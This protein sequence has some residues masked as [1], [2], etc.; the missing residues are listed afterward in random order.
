MVLRIEWAKIGGD[1]GVWYDR[2]HQWIKRRSQDCVFFASVADTNDMVDIAQD[3]F[4]ELIRQDA[5][6]ISKSKQAMVGEDG[7]QAHRTGVKQGFV[8]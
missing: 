1:D 2:D 7:P 4:E 8:T 3:E 5:R 6:C